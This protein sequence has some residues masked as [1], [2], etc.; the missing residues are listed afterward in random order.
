MIRV[1]D[2]KANDD[3]TLDLKFSDGSIK[4]FDVKPY[5]KYGVFTELNDLNY[6]KKVKLAFGTIQWPN[7]QDIA[8]DT[9]FLEGTLLD[10][11]NQNL[12]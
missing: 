6:F 2:V 3:F 1:V 10:S 11:A 9:L 5:L 7:E 12:Q 4:R 8:P